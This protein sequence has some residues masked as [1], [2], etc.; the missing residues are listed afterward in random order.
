MIKMKKDKDIE[1]CSVEC[2][3]DAICG[4]WK[5]III[6]HLLKYGILRFSQLQKMLKNIVTQRMLTMQLRDLE[7]QGIIS[8]N[9]YPTVPPKVEYF[10]TD[11]GKSLAVIIQS[12][13]DWGSNYY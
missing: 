5:G 3:L 1:G 2:A 13:N 8:R 7:E 9:I 6:F 4:K 11:K 12:L 10:L